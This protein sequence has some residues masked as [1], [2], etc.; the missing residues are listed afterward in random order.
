MQSLQPRDR[1]GNGEAHTSSTLQRNSERR[2]KFAQLDLVG[3]TH[4]EKGAEIK[5][6]LEK[7]MFKERKTLNVLISFENKWKQKNAAFMLRGTAPRPYGHL[8]W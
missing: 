5:Q 8:R 4:T 3:Q 2:K 7:K 6:K 1:S